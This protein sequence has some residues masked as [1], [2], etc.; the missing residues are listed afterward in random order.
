MKDL[1]R[2]I[3]LPEL[4]EVENGVSLNSIMESITEQYVDDEN[5]DRRVP[6]V[7]IKQRLQKS[8]VYLIVRFNINPWLFVKLIMPTLG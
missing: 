5:D 4:E 1:N 3:V 2:L 8:I 7:N 6:L